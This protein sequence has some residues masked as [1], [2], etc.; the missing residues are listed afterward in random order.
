MTSPT[1]NFNEL[2][3]DSLGLGLK[4]EALRIAAIAHWGIESDWGNSARAIKLLNFADVPWTLTM[5]EFGV[6]ELHGG[7][8][9][10]HFTDRDSF[11]TG[12]WEHLAQDLGLQ[13]AHSTPATF[14][15]FLAQRFAPGDAAYAGQLN[16]AIPVAQQLYTEAVETTPRVVFIRSARSVSATISVTTSHQQSVATGAPYSMRQPLAASSV[17]AASKAGKRSGTCRRS[18]TS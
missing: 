11:L 4:Y 15:Q 8:P 1:S 5:L 18:R 6:K 3:E 12:Y 13:D 14:A 10:C 17:A 16:G 2:I 7:L 9:F